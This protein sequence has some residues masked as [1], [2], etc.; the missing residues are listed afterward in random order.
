MSLSKLI[1][2]QL[3]PQNVSFSLS[4]LLN[5]NS[6]IRV[7]ISDFL[8]GKFLSTIESQEFG[9]SHNIAVSINN[10]IKLLPLFIKAISSEKNN[11]AADTLFEHRELIHSLY[12]NKEYILNEI[13][14][15]LTEL[16]IHVRAE[17][18]KKGVRVRSDIIIMKSGGGQKL[19]EF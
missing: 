19:L 1:Y 12:Y 9:A 15:I 13:I 14:P 16:E 18:R 3:N 5:P 4:D 11:D 7:F 17:E 8:S 6:K 10:R 2:K